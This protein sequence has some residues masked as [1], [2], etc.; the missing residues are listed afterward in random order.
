MALAM[1]CLL[2]PRS[3][4][5][6]PCPRCGPGAAAVSRWPTRED[7]GPFCPLPAPL[8]HSKDPDSWGNRGLGLRCPVASWEAAAFWEAAWRQWPQL[9]RALAKKG[10]GPGYPCHLPEVCLCAHDR[11][12]GRP[13]GPSETVKGL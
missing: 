4:P 6:V 12:K 11:P 1:C 8:L 10:R 5:W 2:H 13:H 3:L 9:Q 7:R